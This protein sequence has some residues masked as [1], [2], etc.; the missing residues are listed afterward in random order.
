MKKFII[1][2]MCIIL[3]F[4]IISS[5]IVKA[6]P[7][8]SSINVEELRNVVYDKLKVFIANSETSLNGEQGILYNL[9]WIIQSALWVDF[10][11][12]DD[13]LGFTATEKKY[14][15]D[16][17]LK[18]IDRFNSS[19]ADINK[20]ITG[21]KLNNTGSE[22]LKELNLRI[23]I[24]NNVSGYFHN[25]LDE[26]AARYNKASTDDE[27][28]SVLRDSKQRLK[29]I[30]LMLSKLYDTTGDI[31]SVIPRD[32]ATADGSYTSRWTY[33]PDS[34]A[35]SEILNN[36]K[37]STI[38]SKGKEESNKDAEN[39]I[40]ASLNENENAE[41]VKQLATENGNLSKAYIAM[42]AASAVYRPFQSRTGDDDFIKV[43]SS[44]VAKS[45]SVLTTYKKA[46]N[47]KK[48][49]YKRKIDN[50]GNGTGSARRITIQEFIEDLESENSGVL[51]TPKGQLQKSPDTNSYEYYN[52]LEN[53]IDW[54]PKEKTDKEKEE[55]KDKETEGG[56]EKDTKTD[57]KTKDTS[58]AIGIADN[59]EITATSDKDISAP[60]FAYG[61]YNSS[62]NLYMGTIL[63]N[64]I[65]K[66]L[67]GTSELK[68]SKAR[69]LYINMLG[70]I[71]TDDDIVIIPAAANPSYLS[72]NFNYYPYTAAFMNHY[73]SSLSV[74]NS[75]FRL[76]SPRD[77]DKY[78]LSYDFKLG[79]DTQEDKL[80]ETE[81]LQKLYKT[82]VIKIKSDRAVA[83]GAKASLGIDT[84]IKDFGSGTST[85]FVSRQYKFN[86]FGN[87][88]LSTKDDN[89][90]TAIFFDSD[91]WFLVKD[92]IG[93]TL[94]NGL[95]L[96]FPY[97]G[98]EEEFEL[99]ELIG[100]NM[101]WSYTTDKDGVMGNLN[102]RLD[103]GKLFTSVIIPTRGGLT[104]VTAYSKN[105]IQDYEQ[106]VEQA[107]NRLIVT[108]RDLV[109][110][111]S[112]TF[113]NINGVLGIKSSYQ[114]P[115]LGK[116]LLFAEKY[117]V[118]LLL[119]VAVIV[120]SK[121]LKDLYSF[122]YGIGIT[123]LALVIAFTFIRILPTYLPSTYNFAVNNIGE[124][125]YY[126]TLLLKSEKYN[127]TYGQSGKVDRDGR[128]TLSTSSI[129][130][131]RLKEEHIEELTARFNITREALLSG[132]AYMLDEDNGLFLEGNNVKMN[133]DK[134]FY[135]L[136]ITGNYIKIGNRSIY[137]FQ[138]EKRVSSILDYYGPYYQM[139]DSFIE[140]LNSFAEVYEVPRGVLQY[141]DK[142]SKDSFL[143]Y[144][145]VNS[146]IYLTP[147]DFSQEESGNIDGATL[148]QIKDRFGSSNDFLGLAKVIKQPEKEFKDTLWYRTLEQN[149]FY[150]DE[151][152]MNDLIY[153]VNFQTRKFITDINDQIRWISDENLIKIISL[154]AW[155]AFNQK[156]SDYN[157]F[158]YPLSINYEELKLG[159]VLL[160]IFTTQYDRFISQN[161][162][163]VN[164]IT[165]NYD[166]FN[167][168]IFGITQGL[169]YLFILLIT[170]TV[171]VLYIALAILLLVRFFIGSKL[172]PVTKGYIKSSFIIFASYSLYNLL[173]KG[174]G[175]VNDDVSKLWILLGGSGLLLF[176]LTSVILS[177]V[178]N[179]TELGN[180]RIDAT[181]SNLVNKLGMNHITDMLK[182]T[183]SSIL[184]REAS[185]GYTSEYRQ[186]FNRYNH[187]QGVDDSLDDSY[188]V[189]NVVRG[190]KSE[191]ITYRQREEYIDEDSIYS[192][193]KN[194]TNYDIDFDELER[195]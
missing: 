114:D 151:E 5:T 149:G 19:Y 93:V 134:L 17:I 43:L 115:I 172:L 126:D 53:S 179:F 167:L 7:Q 119:I 152:K 73:P 188:Y 139:V 142:F 84:S 187:T 58:M 36:S 101:Y 42:I 92:N 138:A 63:M 24:D 16:F 127:E 147:G 123:L 69:F 135:T 122:T 10:I 128:L 105:Y 157:N 1:N 192:R 131:Y 71:V 14:Y 120:I 161:M 144:N 64:N 153:Y 23:L 183:T 191:P 99:A 95:T 98:S 171:P 3:T 25:V 77:I 136:P 27:K 28:A 91:N 111:S 81:V 52:G 113:E 78:I 163:I 35:F 26:I 15:N 106:F 164:Y 110:N 68:N 159:D 32:K 18:Y 104:N 89:L 38:L 62:A 176:I 48:P 145:F 9:D 34:S 51:V 55:N 82:E 103:E 117:L 97:T 112:K 132:K 4:N 180:S 45:D 129:N 108:I 170:Y 195:N 96:T 40:N 168:I 22:Q 11:N 75:N 46:K 137:Q 67:K 61:R 130:L 13:S 90:P 88:L 121:Y 154:K 162:D 72:K 146:S 185:S 140:Q 102:G 8:M 193:P 124:K 155:C 6:E 29:L 184:R 182:I 37:Y 57:T 186:R 133:I 49:L 2:I 143:V 166:W 160:P 59:G 177:V 190:V 86:V 150:E 83:N 194:K 66:D 173:L 85:A 33:R 178:L 79:K 70:D 39:T 12:K 87:K 41:L 107:S 169:N 156:A 174:V 31:N 118:Y 65:L 94:K 165:V 60:V 30:Y 80:S 100:K 21:I 189:D 20:N 50:S 125:L 148:E 47:F 175:Y 76:S 116:V 44:M 109:K 54:K 56:S 141:T 181:V 74:I 158:M